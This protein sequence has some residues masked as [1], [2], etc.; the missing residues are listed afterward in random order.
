M[1]FN[2]YKAYRMLRVV[3]IHDKKTAVCDSE[4]E[5]VENM[6]KE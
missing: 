5:L 2:L 1:Q 6:S 4:N 3:S